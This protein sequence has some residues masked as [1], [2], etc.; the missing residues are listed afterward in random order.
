MAK[1]KMDYYINI[2][3]REGSKFYDKKEPVQSIGFRNG[4]FYYNGDPTKVVPHS[5]I[6][7][8]YIIKDGSYQQVS[9]DA[10]VALFRK[11]K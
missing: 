2:K 11:W 7:S 9:C 4:T 5:D 1:L 6:T 10:F 3:M 8:V